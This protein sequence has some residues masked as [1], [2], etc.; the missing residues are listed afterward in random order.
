[1]LAQATHRMSGHLRQ[2]TALMKQAW[3]AGNQRQNWQESINHLFKSF[4]QIRGPGGPPDIR[5]ALA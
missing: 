2:Q 1:M 4:M 5:E 3:P